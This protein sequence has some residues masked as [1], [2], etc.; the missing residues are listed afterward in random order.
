MNF[1]DDNFTADKDRAKEICRRMITDD[2][3]RFDMMNVTFKP[4][5]MTPWE[6][7]E[8][9]YRAGAFFY[10]DK[11]SNEIGRIFGREYGLRRRAFGHISKLGIW[12]AHFCADHVKST[13]YYDLKHYDCSRPGVTLPSSVRF[14]TV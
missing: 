2:W 11:S 6:L 5:N 14:N 3:S 12:G 4:K 8:E 9:F 1:E 7:Q 10:D 13:I